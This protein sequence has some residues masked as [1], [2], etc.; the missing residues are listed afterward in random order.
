MYVYGP[1]GVGK[2]SLLGEFAHICR[3]RG[4]PLARL[5]GRQLDPSPESLLDALRV[6][7][8]LEPGAAPVEALA[9]RPRFVLLI[10]TYEL[11]APLDPW[12]RE[13]LLASLPDSVLTVIA[14]RAPPA[15]AWRA[16]PGWQSLLHVVPLRNLTPN[17]TREL[18]RRRNVVPDRYSSVL[19]FTHGHPLAAALVV[20]VLSQRPESDFS[21]DLQID[22]VRLLLDQLVQRVPGPAHRRALEC[23]A[24]VSTTSESLLSELL[25]IPDAHELFEWLGGLSFI[26]HGPHGIFPHD[27]VREVL[28]ADLRWR[29][30]DWFAELHRRARKVYIRRFEEARGGDQ[31]RV[32]LDY[33]FLHRDNP[34]VKPFFEW[35]QAGSVRPEPARPD[36]HPAV[37]QMVAANEGATAA[38][39]AESYLSD[40][41][42]MAIVV[43]DAN[44]QIAG[45]VG[46]LA[47]T[48]NAAQLS[49]RDPA[50]RAAVNYLD[51]N[52]PLREGE[53][54]TLFRFWMARESYQAVSAVQS[55][56]FLAAVRHYL[57]APRLAFS[58]FPCADPDFWLP[59]FT[60]ADLER[61]PAADFEIDG[62]R[63]GVFGHDWR[64][65]PP[66]AWL[67]LLGERETADT[68]AVQPAPTPP[69][70]LVLSQP[71][72]EDAVREALRGFT[73]PDRLAT[74]PLLRSRTIVDQLPPDAPTAERVAALR[75]AITSVAG[76]LQ[77]S[78]RDMKRYEA[79]RHVYFEPAP[80][81]ERAAELADVPFSTFRRYLSEGVSEIA[82]A[83]W[84]REVG[85][86]LM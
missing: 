33:I 41:G 84:A 13:G 8:G 45:F 86:P 51:A 63:Y 21:E 59:V 4:V 19:E 70:V 50:V 14:G 44:D 40:P 10:D 18:L 60:Y 66:L 37:V 35:Q 9:G 42:F 53:S 80:S 76:R 78:P 82:L 69:A 34:V 52:A 39:L 6:A 46:M 77:S 73:R 31:Q 62:R 71:D 55:V 81:Q 75:E 29:D 2:T 36:D 22:I 49:K 30:P 54:A 25:D 72:F 7:L 5:D 1:G 28:N 79:L 12:V 27:I 23:I 47:I 32:L 15:L 43:R 57:T 65:R 38:R 56:I 11:L 20:D 24:V 48:P 58:L 85:E 61:L 67:E 16:D 3:E 68:I 74:N 64:V 17:E 83:L 26:D